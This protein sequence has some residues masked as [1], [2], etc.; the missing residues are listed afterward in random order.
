[1]FRSV[2]GDD[3]RPPPPIPIIP[4]N[5]LNSA[6]A[7]SN[8]PQDWTPTQHSAAES[9]WGVAKPAPPPQSSGAP[10]ATNQP[11]LH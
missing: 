4:D 8:T 10:P 1:V 6:A 3:N 5:T 7:E 11:T 9:G 2:G